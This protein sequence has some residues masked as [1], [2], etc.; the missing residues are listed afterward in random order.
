MARLNYSA[1]VDELEQAAGSC[2]T[3]ANI[4]KD[5]GEMLDAAFFFGM[6]VGIDQLLKLGKP[7]D[8]AMRGSFEWRYIREELTDGE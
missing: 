2:R 3:R 1:T 8:A 4:H 7:E 6:Q 5:N